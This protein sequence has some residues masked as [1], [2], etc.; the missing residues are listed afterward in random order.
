[1]KAKVRSLLGVAAALLLMV[2]AQPAMAISVSV[3]GVPVAVTAGD[4]FNVDVV[5][6][7]ITNEIITAWDIDV[8]FDPS[9]LDNGL[10]TIFLGPFGGAD[11][12]TGGGFAPGLSDAF[13][14]SLL[15]DAEIRALQCP[16]NVCAP[17]LTIATFNFTALLDGSPVISLVNWGLANDIKCE[18]N[19][20]CYPTVPEPGT[21]ALLSLGLLGLGL[22]RRRNA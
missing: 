19:R 5:I 15:T 17:S 6:S 7:G 9:L 21:L 20:Q 22:R 11:T 16:G 14:V 12:V 8:A 13:L 1:M 3:Q 2:S 4:N 18:N 10:I